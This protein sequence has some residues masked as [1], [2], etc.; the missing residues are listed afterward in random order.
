MNQPTAQPCKPTLPGEKTLTNNAPSQA[1]LAH[2]IY[3]KRLL[4][5]LSQL[6]GCD[7][8]FIEA[9]HCSNFFNR[10]HLQSTLLGLLDLLEL[11]LQQTHFIHIDTTQGSAQ[12]SPQFLRYDLQI[13]QH[14]LLGVTPTAITHPAQIDYIDTLWQCS[15]R[16]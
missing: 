15:S 1:D 2:A 7:Y 13:D 12:N 6:M 4:L 10:A 8:V 9:T 11:N 16:Y 5:S 14:T 3:Q